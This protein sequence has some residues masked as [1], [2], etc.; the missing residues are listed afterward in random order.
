MR[1][2]VAVVESLSSDQ[3]R[4]AVPGQAFLGQAFFRRYGAG[5]TA[6]LLLISAA[7]LSGCGED[8][9][10]AG[11]PSA[12]VSTTTDVDTSVG[13]DIATVDV[14]PDVG[15]DVAVDV[16][17][18]TVDVQGDTGSDTGGDASTCPGSPGC[19]CTADSACGDKGKCVGDAAGVKKCAA[20]C[21]VA[22]DCTGGAVCKDIGGTSYCVPPKVSLCA[23]CIKDTDCQ[24]Q[25]LSDAACV[26][27]GDA[28]KFCG[29][30]CTADGD[31]GDGYSCADVK[32]A[33]GKDLKQ[34]KLKTGTCECSAY[35]KAIGAK[36]NC[37]VTNAN[38]TCTAERKCGA[39]GLEACTAKSANAETCNAEDDNC[40]GKIDNLAAD[41]NCFTE[42]FLEQGTL[43][44]CV[45]DTDC[46]AQG[47]TCDE[48]AGKCKLLI[49][50]CPGV[51][52]CGSNGSIV[53]L[54]AKTPTLEDCDGV[55][56]DCDGDIDEGFT[57]KSLADGADLKVGQACGSGACAGGTVKCVDKL[58][59]TCDSFKNSAKESCD[60]LDNDCNGKTDDL[61][62][63]DNDACTEDSCDGA[64]KTCA[65][66]AKDC[67]DG[68]SCTEDKCDSK[69]GACSNDKAIGS[70]DDGNPCSV[71]DVCGDDGKG[72]WACIP[73]KDGQKCDDSNPCT[74]DKCA[75]GTGCA[76]TPNAA[77][78]PC[79][80][81]A[82]GTENKGACK[83][84]TYQ[85]KDGK[86]DNAACVGQVTPASSEQCDGLDDTC[87]GQ[88]DETCKPTAVAVT[89][90]S[91]QV[92]GKTADNKTI[93]LLIGPQG[94]VGNAS[95]GKTYDVR[96][97]FYAWLMQLLGVK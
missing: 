71:G 9:T 88:T 73:G 44:A 30:A 42:A 29:A 28:G 80:T 32:D 92:S 58:T 40:D 61:A 37:A 1:S 89:F 81:G 70:C 49:G 53:C 68:K 85:C 16:E 63:E 74:D 96:F 52:Q 51:P 35:A 41:A 39:A 22:G 18:D 17:A 47:E 26:D 24:V 3:P 7:G 11:E 60:A 14:Q 23:P 20:T 62:C 86:L 8:Q 94:P 90:S 59:A 75:L 76:Y 84:G 78:V 13:T 79:Y 97:G 2:F 38:G 50:K 69:T 82:A 5:L 10:V 15:T 66:K 31:C 43:A 83:A 65:N 12:D 34:C 67:G 64:A 54:G 87:N 91:A 27:Y 95:G 19:D 45:K 25:G 93:Q 4:L 55:D 33:S 21:K 6:G 36:T 48:K 57:W 72:G 56:N 46:T 77:T